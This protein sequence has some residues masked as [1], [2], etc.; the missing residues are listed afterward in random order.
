MY[1]GRYGAPGSGYGGRRPSG[2]GGYG[3]YS[4]YEGFSDDSSQ[5]E[6]SNLDSDYDEPQSRFPGD[7]G[8]RHGMTP[9]GGMRP[10]PGMPPMFGLASRPGMRGVP[11]MSPMSGMR[12][13]PGM[14]T[15]GGMGGISGM[16][17]MDDM[18]DMD[19]MSEMGGMRPPFG[20]Q[21]G[22][23]GRRNCGGLGAAVVVVHSLLWALIGTK[24]LKLNEPCA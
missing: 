20:G 16:D 11:G 19:Q 18:D 14:P 4:S 10:R 7:M 15:M 21:P 13:R 6:Y 9:I 22:G 1:P 5:E 2:F 17:D 23:R 12:S 8:P 24:P 3:G